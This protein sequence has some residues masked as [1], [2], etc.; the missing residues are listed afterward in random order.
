MYIFSPICLKL[1]ATWIIIQRFNFLFYFI[2]LKLGAVWDL[3]KD[4]RVRLLV[5]SF[6]ILHTSQQLS[7]INAVFYYST[8]FFEGI[9]SDPLIGTAA[10]GVVNVV[11]TYVALK[12][13]DK[14]GRVTLMLW[15]TG[16]E[17]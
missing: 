16:G 17:N 8:S 11:A 9:I 4:K 2:F 5:V 13:M 6:V 10:V 14:T 12:L 1:G 3:I 7:G 15:S